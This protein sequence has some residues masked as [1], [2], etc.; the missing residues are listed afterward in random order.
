[1]RHL[2]SCRELRRYSSMLGMCSYLELVLEGRV[3]VWSV[4]DDEVVVMCGCL[5]RKREKKRERKKR[6][7]MKERKIGRESESA[8]T[9]ILRTDMCHEP[10]IQ[11]NYMTH[12]LYPC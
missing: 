4:D 12:P 2:T 10:P 9:P 7:K 11:N 8:M 6:E 3:C 1:M 5:Q